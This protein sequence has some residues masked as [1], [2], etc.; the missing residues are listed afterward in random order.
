MT[1]PD[2]SDAPAF[3]RY[4]AMDTNGVWCWYEDKPKL[5]HYEWWVSGGECCRAGISNWRDTLEERPVE[6]E[7]K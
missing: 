6:A 4:L 7:G 1:K 3:A 2:W 5:G